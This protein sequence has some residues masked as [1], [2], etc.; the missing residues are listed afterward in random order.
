MEYSTKLYS[1][2]ELHAGE[3]LLHREVGATLANRFVPAEHGLR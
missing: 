2:G 1:L 3:D